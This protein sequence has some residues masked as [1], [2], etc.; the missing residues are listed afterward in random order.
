[1][2]RQGHNQC[3]SQCGSRNHWQPILARAAAPPTSIIAH[4]R[5]KVLR[6]VLTSQPIAAPLLLHN[7]QE[8]LLARWTS[9]GTFMKPFCAPGCRQG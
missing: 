3:S 8:S 5:W 7:L 1:M 6:H 9:A 2:R 4:G